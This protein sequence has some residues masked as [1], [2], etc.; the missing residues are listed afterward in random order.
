MIKRVLITIAAITF[1][2]SSFL[3]T[4]N[5][6]RNQK[7]KVYE[8][9]VSLF[10]PSSVSEVVELSKTTKDR[11]FIL[12]GVKTCPDCQKFVPKLQDALTSTGFDF[13]KV[14]YIGFDK[15]SDI[16]AVSQEEYQ[17]L[18]HGVAGVPLLVKVVNGVIV[19]PY[20]GGPELREYL[21][22]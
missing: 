21:L 18:S 8:E 9:R 14:Y 4:L 11:Y 12:I 16:Q 13:K 15:V 22:Y 7:V 10:T 5:Y 6:M 17:L 20:S 3:I 2:A 19:P 1:M